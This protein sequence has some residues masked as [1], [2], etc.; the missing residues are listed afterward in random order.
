VLPTTLIGR[1]YF[2]SN[3]NITPIKEVR[4]FNYVNSQYTDKR[5]TKDNYEDLCKYHGFDLSDLDISNKMRI[6]RNVVNP[7]IGLHVFE[8]AFKE[9]QKT[10][11]PRIAKS[12][13]I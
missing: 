6:I 2:W 7:K 1:H 9:K 5:P 4:Q 3:Y 10:L 11:F 13:K 8:C 12:G